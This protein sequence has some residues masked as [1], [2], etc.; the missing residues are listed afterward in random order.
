MLRDVSLVYKD[1]Y[2]MYVERCKFGMG[3]GRC[4]EER[5]ML[6]GVWLSP[7]CT[8]VIRYSLCRLVST[9]SVLS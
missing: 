2:S 6:R 7:I 4:V 3:L 9:G 8:A 1:I 5:M